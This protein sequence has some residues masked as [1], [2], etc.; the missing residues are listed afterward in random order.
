M[1]RNTR[2]V[3]DRE[4]LLT[5]KPFEGSNLEVKFNIE[6]KKGSKLKPFPHNMQL[7]N[8]HLLQ[9]KYY[10][11]FDGEAAIYL[12]NAEYINFSRL[13]FDIS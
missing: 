7:N 12:K 8:K 10:H 4:G 6:R 9:E 5:I 13:L 3:V 11:L 1:K 2:I